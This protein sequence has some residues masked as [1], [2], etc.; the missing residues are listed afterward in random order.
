MATASEQA[1]NKRHGFPGLRCPFCGAEDAT[2]RVDL[3]DTAQFVCSD[4]ECE[5]TA[6]D[7][8]EVMDRWAAVLAWVEAAPVVS[9]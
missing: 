8:R 1:T 3:A 9:D 6:D 7:V 2:I 4:N 5:F